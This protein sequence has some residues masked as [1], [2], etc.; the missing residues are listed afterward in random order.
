VR[1]RAIFC[2][3]PRRSGRFAGSMIVNALVEAGF[4]IVA[5]DH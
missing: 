4:A 3:R 1:R 2:R 5:A